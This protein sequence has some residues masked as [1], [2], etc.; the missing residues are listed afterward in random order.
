[1][2]T[3]LPVH[4]AGSPIDDPAAQAALL[5]DA[6]ASSDALLVSRALHDIARAQGQGYSF[7]ED[8]ALSVVLAALQAMNLELVAKPAPL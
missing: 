2:P 3:D 4:E 6:L 7:G 8:P 5:T 1:M